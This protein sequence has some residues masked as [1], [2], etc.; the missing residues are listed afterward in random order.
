M[1]AQLQLHPGIDPHYHMCPRCIEVTNC[2]TLSCTH[3]GRTTC[4]Q[5]LLYRDLFDQM[6]AADIPPSQCSGEDFTTLQLDAEDTQAVLRFQER[7]RAA[8]S[9][10]EA[11][12]K[13]LIPYATPVART[14]NRASTAGPSS[15][16]H[17][18]VWR[19]T[20]RISTPEEI[21]TTRT[22]NHI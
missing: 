11:S 15:Y 13:G 3:D 14:V 21:R 10:I 6:N 2:D 17:T 12:I 16:V 20:A 9:Q 5:C 22:R 4:Y 7:S 18:P 8:A 19:G 1:I